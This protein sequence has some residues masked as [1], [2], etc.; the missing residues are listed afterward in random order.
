VKHR[1]V[2]HFASFF[3]FGFLLG[4]TNA[5]AQ[6]IGYRQTNLASN[7]P[8][9]ANNVTPGLVNPWGIAFLSD[10]P[11][12]I[13]DNNAGRV[14]AQDGTGL[15]VVPGSFIVPNA[16]GTGF[17]T[18]TGIVA[19]QNSFFGD[20]SVV[21]PFILVTEEGTIL[22]WG[23]DAH[24]DLPL[25]ATPRRRIASAVYKGTAILNSPF[26]APAL[27]VTDFLH[28]DIETFLP[29]FAQVAL[30]GSFTDP[31]LPPGYAPFGIQ[32]I[33]AQV[34]VSYALQDAAKHDPIFGVGNGVVSIFD[35]DGNFMK[36][37]A[38]GGALNAPWGITQASANF[39][40]FSNDILIGNVGDGNI[41]AFDPTTGQ[42]VGVLVDGNG[43]DLAE[44]GLHGLAFRADGF[45]DPNTLYFTSQLN[46]AD[47]GVFG[48]ITPG[49]VSTI[50]ISA[51]NAIVDSNATLTAEVAAGPGN[52]GSPT[53]TVTFLD[54]ST[55]LGTAP[56]VNGSA[57]MNAV[58]ANTGIHPITAQY[59]GDRVFLP[60][61]DV[62]PMQVTG[63]ATMSTLMAPANVAPGSTVTLTATIN[64]AGGIPTGQVAFLDG[65]TNLGASPLNGAGVAALRINTLTAGTHTLT[66]SYSGDGKFDVST[67][68]AATINIANADFS[69]GANPSTAM[70]T[71]GQSTQ[72]MLTVTPAGG[73]ANNVTFSCSP[74]TGITCTFNPA[75]VTPANGTA[76][77][78]LTVT[79]S[80]TVTRYGFLLFDRI[81]PGAL[82]STLALFGLLIWRG[83]NL[84]NASAPLLTATAVL[85]IVALSVTLGGCGGYGSNTQPNR[86]TAS[87]MVIAQSGAISHTTTV[88]V[89]VQ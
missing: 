57:S 55:R 11:F 22:T 23:P 49:L 35:M 53:G 79:T 2:L 84:R 32:V 51:P 63:L 39:G 83:G 30:P 89:T 17:D 18:P 72:F 6:T 21:K 61:H 25:Q 48:A 27:A 69:L 41:N 52:T 47:N 46:S 28:G 24:G 45:G 73:F 37:F 68:A 50:R 66:A 12:F 74:I 7:L 42:L 5:T 31:N 15:G 77:T 65:T 40:P 60:R 64:S 56:L 58:L 3:L 9:V 88:K 87:I 33:G 29:G 44:V 13:T 62:I 20:P 82:L 81:G 85:A 76:S 70:V 67:S 59:S 8:N 54:G 4:S 10:Q 80:A 78:T 43:T 26:T 14:T 86:G 16:A 75:M 19:D 71:A 38:T 34:F 1:I 36:R